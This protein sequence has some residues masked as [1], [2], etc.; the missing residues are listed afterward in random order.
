MALEA[1]A[2]AAEADAPWLS[3]CHWRSEGNVSE[4]VTA[5]VKLPSSLFLL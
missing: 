2:G 5:E 1:D 3:G 4:A